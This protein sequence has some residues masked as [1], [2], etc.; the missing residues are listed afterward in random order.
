MK[1]SALVI[2]A[3]ALSLFSVSVSAEMTGKFSGVWKEKPTANA[4]FTISPDGDNYKLVI[5]DKNTGEHVF[6]AVEEK[7]QLFQIVN[8]AKRPLFTFVDKDT[9]KW[10][11]LNANLKKQK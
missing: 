11:K 5:E 1:K 9:L 10:T 6:Q 3:L 8:G 7:E 4:K 2:A